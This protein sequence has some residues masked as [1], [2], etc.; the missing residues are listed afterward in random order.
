MI[1][2]KKEWSRIGFFRS[3]ISVKYNLTLEI[4]EKFSGLKQF[5]VT[6]ATLS[7]LFE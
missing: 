6:L 2:E 5:W 7:E 4:F 3:L 1:A